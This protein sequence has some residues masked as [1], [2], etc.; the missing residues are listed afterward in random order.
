MVPVV[1]ARRRA[2]TFAG[3]LGFVAVLASGCKGQWSRVGMPA[4][5]TKQGHDLLGLWYGSM[6]TAAIVGGFVILLIV[7]SAYRFRRRSPDDL[8]RQV[9]YNLPIEVLYTIIPIVIVSVLF[10]FTALRENDQDSLSAHPGLRINVVGFQW[11]W[12]FNYLDRGLSITGRPGEPPQLVVPVGTPIRFYEQSA[13]VVHAFWVVPFLFKRDVIPGRIN[14]FE[15]TVTKAGTFEGKCTEYC[16]VDH[17]RMLFTVLALPKDQYDA[18]IAQ[19]KQVAASGLDH[20]YSVYT[21]PTTPV[22]QRGDSVPN[23]QGP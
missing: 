13:D 6:L 23:L 21:G 11:S 2:L 12:Q 14:V 3:G 15:V 7:W 8:P 9:R 20:R 16:G 1:P 5:V 22:E 18:R 10:Y 19:L 4:P 17:D